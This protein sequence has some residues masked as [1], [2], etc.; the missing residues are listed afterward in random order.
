MDLFQNSSSA[1]AKRPEE[2]FHISTSSK[3]SNFSRRLSKGG[4]A[5]RSHSDHELDDDFKSRHKVLGTIGSGAFGTVS[6]IQ[7]RRKGSVKPENA[8]MKVASLRSMDDKSKQQAKV[9]V[10]HMAEL[11][12]PN[13]IGYYESF[14][15]NSELFI[16]MEYANGGSLDGV[17]TKRKK[18]GTRI[19]VE[20]IRRWF[21]EMLLAV[22]FV[23]SHQKMHR[24]LKTANIFLHKDHV[25][26]GDFGL[27][28]AMEGDECAQTQAGTMYYMAPELLEGSYSYPADVWACGVVLYELCTLRRPFPAKNAMQ[29]VMKIMQNNINIEKHFRKLTS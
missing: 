3:M 16:V 28:R 9:E 15:L 22:G 27:A 2:V 12:H 17:I 21:T 24:D 29:L 18:E 1:K 11:K 26:L 20:K 6:L 10:A 5:G 4:R 7:Y 25:K 19:P 23:H 14:I 8:A 13:I